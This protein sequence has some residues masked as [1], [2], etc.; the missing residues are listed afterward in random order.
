MIHLPQHSVWCG[1]CM[2]FV[3]DD[4]PPS[5]QCVGVVNVWSLW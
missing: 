4:T 3:V 1:K 2:E 5:A